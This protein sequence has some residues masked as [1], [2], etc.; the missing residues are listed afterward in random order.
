MS[1]NVLKEKSMAFAVRCVRL[2]K[3]LRA[4]K[5]EYILSKQLLRSGTSIGANIQESEY[6]Q[7]RADFASKLS[8]ACKEAAETRYWI[9]LLANT[10]YISQPQA[11]S[12]TND[13]SELISLLVSIR[14]RLQANP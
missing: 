14:K 13:C 8:I 11:L 7:S 1:S 4:E 9:E 12:M 2:C 10:N 6:A 5:R 3:Y